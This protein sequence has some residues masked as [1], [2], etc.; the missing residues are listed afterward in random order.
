MVLPKKTQT[1]V[2]R[3]GTFWEQI[4][5]KIIFFYKINYLR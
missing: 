4:G 3:F 1:E 5:T 2:L